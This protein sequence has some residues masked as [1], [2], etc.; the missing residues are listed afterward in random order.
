M[1]DLLHQAQREGLV[2]LQRDRKGVWR[3][4]AVS[5]PTPAATVSA[6]EPTLQAAAES[7]PVAAPP[8][9]VV[10]TSPEAE[11]RLDSWSSPEI[12]AA[13]PPDRVEELP[14]AV[15]LPLEVAPSVIEE[16]PV[17]EPPAEGA[18]AGRKARRP[19]SARAKSGA[20]KPASR[21]KGKEE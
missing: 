19:R 14:Q 6:P 15:T 4:F 16:Q 8:E 10:P 5:P 20:R 12:L 18:S 13:T 11:V 7:E 3:I 17:A 9:V 2:R 1:L 21:R